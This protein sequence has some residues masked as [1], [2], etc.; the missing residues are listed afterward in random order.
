MNNHRTFET[1]RYIQRGKFFDKI[2]SFLSTFSSNSF[3]IDDVIKWDYMGAAEFEHGA[4]GKSFSRMKEIMHDEYEII[5]TGLINNEG[6]ECI[7]FC[8]KDQE[9]ETKETILNLAVNEY[10]L[11]EYSYFNEY[12]SKNNVT[13]YYKNINFWWDIVN[14]YMFWFDENDNTL[15]MNRTF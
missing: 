1:P 10:R 5:H 11:K 12:F 14:D 15:T 2:V 9:K 3:K 4:L 13:D 8:K 6:Y 7:V